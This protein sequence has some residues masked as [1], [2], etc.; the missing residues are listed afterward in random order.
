MAQDLCGHCHEI[1]ALLV[2]QLQ[3][4][5]DGCGGLGAVGKRVLCS[6][7][8][9]RDE[10]KLMAMRHAVCKCCVF[11]LVT[12]VTLENLHAEPIRKRL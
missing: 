1:E 3:Y 12:K 2:L 5:R 6:S 8:A 9:A 11:S 4:R 10:R 7:R